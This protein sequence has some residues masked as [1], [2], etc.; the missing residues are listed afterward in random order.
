MAEYPESL[1]FHVERLNAL[2][3]DVC[4]VIANQHTPYRVLSSAAKRAK[5]WFIRRQRTARKVLV[6]RLPDRAVGCAHLTLSQFDLRIVRGHGTW[7]CHLTFAFCRAA[8]S[9]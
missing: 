4:T 2:T 6:P 5:R 7:S 8:P 1:P 9:A 3:T